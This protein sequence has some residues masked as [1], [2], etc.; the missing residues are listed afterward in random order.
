VNTEELG[1]T[2]EKTGAAVTTFP[3]FFRIASLLAYQLPLTLN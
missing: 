2:S 3:S 1:L